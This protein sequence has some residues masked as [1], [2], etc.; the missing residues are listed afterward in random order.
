MKVVGL[1]LGR[2]SYLVDL[3]EIVPAGGMAFAVLA[4]A[5]QS[6]YDFAVMPTLPLQESQQSGLRFEHGRLGDD[7][8]SLISSFEIHPQGLVAQAIDTRVAEVFFEDFFA[9]GKKDFGLRDP[10]SPTKKTYT[11]SLVVDFE[12]DMDRLLSE[13]DKLSALLFGQVKKF[14]Q[15]DV[16]PG[17]QRITLRP[18][19]ELLPPRLAGGLLGDFTLERRVFAPYS[20]QRFYSIAPLPTDAHTLFLEELEKLVL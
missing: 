1:E 18:D 4:S 15:I 14:Y 19:P 17:I 9:A 6:R 16:P 7:A 20:R 3:L 8:R 5:L 2:V 12:T 11:S 13:W 10:T